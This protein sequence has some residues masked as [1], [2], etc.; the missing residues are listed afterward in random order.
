MSEKV[1]KF[2]D[3]ATGEVVRYRRYS[4]RL[5]E[6]LK[7]YGPQRGYRV[8]IEFTD[9]L[10][11]QTGRLLLLREAVIAGK[12][13]SEVGLPS[14]DEDVCTLVCTANLFDSKDR[15]LRSARA[16][17]KILD[18]K[19]FEALETAANQRLIASVGFGG[20]LFDEDEDRDID[21]SDSTIVTGKITA[22]DTPSGSERD[23]GQQSSGDSL[24][25]SSLTD[26]EPVTEG[27]RRHIENLA[28]RADVE[29]PQLRNR[30]DV[31]A[32][33]RQLSQLGRQRRSNGHSTASPADD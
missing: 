3:H 2:L 29:V 19:D 33:Q 4:A 14:I 9:L 6:F 25:T 10:S 20:E 27:E 31:K 7:D 21:R 18:F 22:E 12:K 5:P 16:S 8:E 17:Q 13:P 28:R 24:D 11:L 32:A 23:A 26:D 30:A 1:I 15:L